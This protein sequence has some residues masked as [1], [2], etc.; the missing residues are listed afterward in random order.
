V[1]FT[2]CERA[3]GDCGRKAIRKL[4]RDTGQAHRDFDL[5]SE[6]KLQLEQLQQQIFDDTKKQMRQLVRRTLGPRLRSVFVGDLDEL[7][8]DGMT[9]V[10]VSK[11][12]SVC[13][14][15]I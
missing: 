11:S 9:S 13:L 1:V 8:P 15:W 12:S 2:K 10:S 14:M 4:T 7:M 5:S 3:W 6:A